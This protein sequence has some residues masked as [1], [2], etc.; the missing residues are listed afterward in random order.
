MRG[1][2]ML[3]GNSDCSVAPNIRLVVSAAPVIC[4]EAISMSRLC[5][6]D[7]FRNQTASITKARKQIRFQVWI[8]M[9]GDT[10]SIKPGG[11][12]TVEDEGRA[13]SYARG[14][15][16]RPGRE[17]NLDMQG[18]MSVARRLGEG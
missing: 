14:A 16:P 18:L 8:R 5:N 11:T 6:Q 15:Q 7:S 2:L 13:S 10:D 3:S 9:M 4:I 12:A 17:Q 1:T